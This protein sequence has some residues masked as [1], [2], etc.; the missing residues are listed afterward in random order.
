VARPLQ[1]GPERR[2]RRLPHV[3]RHRNPSDSEP[4]TPHQFEGPSKRRD[5]RAAPE[6]LQRVCHQPG[7]ARVPLHRPVR[8]PGLDEGLLGPAGRAP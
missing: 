8:R 6:P 4:R 1:A 3:G 2:A 7:A 5:R